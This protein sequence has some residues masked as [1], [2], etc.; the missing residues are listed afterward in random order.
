VGGVDDG[1]VR[2]AAL[3]VTIALL[4]LSPEVEFIGE[5]ETVNLA[6]I[7]PGGISLVAPGRFE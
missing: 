3:T 4:G 7:E 1:D 2:T 6:S 5:S